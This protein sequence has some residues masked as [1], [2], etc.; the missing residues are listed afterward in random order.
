M[1]GPV[2]TSFLGRRAFSRGKC[3]ALCASP[4]PVARDL[5]LGQLDDHSFARERRLLLVR[6]ERLENGQPDLE[7][8]EIL[9]R[10]HMLASFGRIARGLENGPGPRARDS[11]KV[12][13]TF[14][15]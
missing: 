5:P 6:I 15:D 13:R 10:R 1:G 11:R 14:R 2:N 7:V 9:S 8:G 4:G 12:L 3:E